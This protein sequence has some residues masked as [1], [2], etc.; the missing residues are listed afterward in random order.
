M[1][2]NKESS[3]GVGGV[4][5]AVIMTDPPPRDFILKGKPWPLKAIKNKKTNPLPGETQQPTSPAPKPSV[6]SLTSQRGSL[7]DALFPK[8]RQTRGPLLSFKDLSAARHKLKT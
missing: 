8:T 3:Q 6:C 1:G 7:S 4:G 5:E 2:E